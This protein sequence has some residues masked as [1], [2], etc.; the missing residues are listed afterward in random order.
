MSSLVDIA[1]D[2]PGNL[3]T[4]EKDLA[5]S[6]AASASN[7]NSEKAPDKAGTDTTSANLPEKLRGKTLEDIASMY[8]NLESTY[9][10]MANDLGQQRKLTD[11]LLDLKRA[12]D[13]GKQTPQ[14]AD[15]KTSDLLERPTETL[16]KFASQRERSLKDTY[17]QRI[18]QLEGSLAQQRFEQKH[19]DYQTTAN[20]PAFVSWVQKSTFRTKVAQAAYNGDWS[21]A[22]ELLTEYKSI[23][24]AVVPKTDDKSGNTNEDG[25]K[26]A[27]AASLDSSGA[28]S[29]GAGSGK[30]TGKI[31][32]R[33]DLMQL[34][35][36]KPD[37][38]YDEGFQ[39][40]ILLAHSQG[41]VK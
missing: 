19:S 15:V 20:D 37:Q 40:E 36:S 7:T 13:L 9:G 4:I 5:E 14:A 2:A 35:I 17:D 12:E 18:A 31:Y 8:V 22:D 27:R 38:Y 10:R 34:R 24:G 28:S 23:K 3:A 25:L 29:D 33:A 21:A 16:E 6:V 1:G 32:R 30:A 26:A 11:R 39:A 41:R